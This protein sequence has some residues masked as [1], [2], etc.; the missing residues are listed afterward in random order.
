MK[1]FFILC[2]LLI[3]ASCSSPQEKKIHRDPDSLNQLENLPADAIK[4]TITKQ[5]LPDIDTCEWL[6]GMKKEN[7]PKGNFI[8]YKRL[9]QN[10][11]QISW[12][13]S[14]LKR[15]L[16]DTFHCDDPPPVKPRFEKENKDYLMLSFW[17]GTSCWGSIYLP[18]H[19]SRPT[20][21]IYYEYAADLDHHLVAALDMDES[22][23]FIVVHN[24]NTGEVQK[25]KLNPQCTSAIPTSCLDSLS[26][27]GKS[28]Y[29]RW[30]TNLDTRKA[31]EYTVKIR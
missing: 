2:V 15:L 7:T 25:I 3:F 30:Y 12:G 6:I 20:K 31:E 21:R 22:G 17:C 19:A 24:L 5:G 23:T 13:S 1:P 28:L 4:D 8:E 18:L 26:I 9:G 29:Y 16:A 10:K 14:M 11:Y 27:N